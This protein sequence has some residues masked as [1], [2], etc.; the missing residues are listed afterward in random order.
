[1]NYHNGHLRNEQDV[2]LCLRAYFPKQRVNWRE[3]I[4]FVLLGAV[5][6]ALFLVS[7]Y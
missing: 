1:M 5:M 4:P 6:L 2:T 3:S 7:L